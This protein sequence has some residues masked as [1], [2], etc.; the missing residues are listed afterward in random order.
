[1]L[2]GSR[3]WPWVTGKFFSPFGTP[4]PLSVSFILGII[5][6]PLELMG[7]E[8]ESDV[9]TGIGLDVIQSA[10]GSSRLLG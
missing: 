2:P 10:A 8:E 3:Y 6:L 1:M 7:H 5:L 9:E 4:H